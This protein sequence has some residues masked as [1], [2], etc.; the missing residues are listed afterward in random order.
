MSVSTEVRPSSGLGSRLSQ[1]FKLMYTF[2]APWEIRRPQPAIVDLFK[3]GQITGKVLDVGCGTGENTIFLAEQ[4]LE[5][6]GIDLAGRAIERAWSNVLHLESRTQHPVHIHFEK[7]D[8]FSVD[9]LGQTFDTIIDSGMFHSLPPRQ[10]ERFAGLLQKI[11]RP[12]GKYHMLCFNNKG[13]STLFPLRVTKEEIYR[14]FREGFTI[15]GI[16]NAK[17]HSLLGPLDAY[18]VTIVRK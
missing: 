13:L 2:R 17:F 4:G 14:I 15:Q 11:L 8:V 6:V 1:M 16:R 18:L 10:R 3:W 12:G 9:K 7:L 5:T